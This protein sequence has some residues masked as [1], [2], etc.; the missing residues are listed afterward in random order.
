MSPTIMLAVLGAA[1]LHAAWNAIA[2]GAGDRLVG[3]T[4]IGLAYTGVSAVVVVVTG[5]PAVAA[6]P[7][8]LASAAVHVLYQLALM[9]SYQ[10]GQFSQAY[11]LARGTSPWVV[12]VVSITVLGQRMPLPE[13]IGVLVVSAGLISLVVLGGR[14]KRADLP[15]LGAAFGTGLLIATYTVIDGV[16]VHRT[17]VASYAGWLFLLQGP[18]VPLLAL[19]VRGRALP[20]GL[21]PSLV[22]GLIGGVVSLAAYGL[23]LWAQARGA[24]AP[25]AALRETSIIFGALI[26]AV[27]FH[28]RLGRGRALASAVVVG[29][30]ILIN[31]R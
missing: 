11:P 23:V 28:E 4:L 9:R 10:L 7:Y 21:R 25:I 27:A 17:G 5:A 29:G 20:V 6:W 26:G 24:L 22:T 12:A 16:G 14:P 18:A 2:H 3:F 13:L 30:V 8:L 15:A 19:A 31:L 1:V